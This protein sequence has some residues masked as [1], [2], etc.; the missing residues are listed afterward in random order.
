VGVTLTGVRVVEA[1]M[2]AGL[3]LGTALA[4]PAS[5]AGVRRRMRSHSRSLLRSEL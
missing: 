4:E 2:G 3:D 5:A 1:T